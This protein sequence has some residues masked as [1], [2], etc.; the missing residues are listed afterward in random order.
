MPYRYAKTDIS[1]FQTS[2]WWQNA[3]IT[4]GDEN[5]PKSPM[6]FANNFQRPY[7][8]PK[9]D[10]SNWKKYKWAKSTATKVHGF[11]PV[12][13][14]EAQYPG[15]RTVFDLFFWQLLMRKEIPQSIIEANIATMGIRIYVVRNLETNEI[16]Y[17]KYFNIKD[18]PKDKYYIEYEAYGSIGKVI[19]DENFWSKNADDKIIQLNRLS[20]L[21]DVESF[22]LL[23][24]I[25]LMLGWANKNGDQ[26]LWNE[27]C[28]F[29]YRMIPSFVMDEDILMRFKLLDIVDDYAQKRTM[30]AF[31]K[32]EPHPKSWRAQRNKF[33]AVYAEHYFNRFTGSDIISIRKIPED[34]RLWWANLLSEVVFEDERLWKKGRELW[35]PANILFIKLLEISSLGD[36]APVR[37]QPIFLELE[38]NKYIYPEDTTELKVLLKEIITLFLEEPDHFD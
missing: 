37:I 27:L 18:Y 23:Q 25:V 38:N 7:T 1:R 26:S 15:T 20:Y 22:Q 9:K 35:R 8:E 36:K 4:L 14:V 13:E 6:W 2:Y 5:G 10:L 21:E 32:P 34:V 33:F 17:P 31:R 3:A 19:L 24:V 16:V 30:V 29:Y 11:H 12:D 28:E